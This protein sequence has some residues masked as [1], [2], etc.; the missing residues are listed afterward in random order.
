MR[1]S[2]SNDFVLC[3]GDLA[4]NHQ[5][6]LSGFSYFLSLFSALR[7]AKMIGSMNAFALL[8]HSLSRLTSGS[9][10][11]K[12]GLLKGLS[13]F[14]ARCASIILIVSVVV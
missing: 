1:A 12:K 7:H 10:G 4:I 9:P 5:S 11:A 8:V 3:S 14:I 2:F 13:F 6:K